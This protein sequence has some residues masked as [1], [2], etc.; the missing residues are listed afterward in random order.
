VIK[1]IDSAESFEAAHAELVRMLDDRDVGG[2]LAFAEGLQSEPAFYADQLLAIA[3]TEGGPILNRRDLIERGAG[4]WRKLNPEASGIVAYNLANAEQGIWELA[5]REKDIALAWEQDRQHL[6]SARQTF[7]RVA[8][9][10]NES[11]ELRAQA[12]TNAGNSYDILG[13][14]LDSLACYD[15]AI[16]LD[17]SF[18]MAY[19]NRGITLLHVAPFMGEHRGGVFRQAAAALD[20]ALSRQDDV[21]RVGGPA[22]LTHFKTERA[23]IRI[24]EAEARSEGCQQVRLDDPYLDWCLRN[25]LFLHV[26][27]DCIREDTQDLDAI[28]FRGLTAG[29]V[30]DERTRVEDLAEAFN[31][32]KQAFA[33]TRYLTWLATDSTSPIREHARAVSRRVYYADPLTYGRYG[34]R[35]GIAIQ[36]LAGAVD[37]LDKIAGFVHLYLRTGRQRDVYFSSIARKRRRGSPL[38]P[39]IA[40]AFVKPERNRGLLA[41]CD[42][43][44][45]LEDD[46]LL[47]RL[48]N[49]RHTATHRFLVIHSI[50]PGTSNAWLDHLGWDELVMGLHQQLAI[51][52][53]AVVYLARVIDIHENLDRRSAAG[54]GFTVTFPLERADTDLEEWDSG[55]A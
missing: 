6:R 13:R 47:R 41:L 42:L 1:R 22:A 37:V 19:G 10:D 34:T 18:A 32:V 30:E 54:G 46:T 24:S 53:G 29:T 16:D 31:A 2:A 28:Y 3:C 50:M 14:D 38:T 35:T 49:L 48:T 12:F 27:H 52:R 44:E 8:H 9:D 20:E 4:L 43:S 17:A 39:E 5:V 55:S 23:S 40:A 33:A 26:S 51:A 15:A 45:D 11:D 36:A 25:Q 7:L 21:M